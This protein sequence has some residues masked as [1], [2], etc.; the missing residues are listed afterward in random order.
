MGR[1][2][3]AQLVIFSGLKI[4][5]L[6]DLS[7]MID[8]GTIRWVFV[9]GSLAMA[10]RKAA[11][12]LEGRSFSLGKAENPTHA[13]EPWYIP[14]ERIEQAKAHDRR[15]KQEGNSIRTA[16]RFYPARW[17]ASETIGPDDQQFDIG[18][19][20]SELFER[21]IGEFLE[22][23][24]SSLNHQSRQWPSTTAYSACSKI[25]ASKRERGVSSRS[26]SG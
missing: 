24:R 12:E 25:H 9:A 26:S 20:T 6:D 5:K 23:V 8:R 18:P 1:C 3:D 14:A 19:K 2:L 15:R 21:K 10:L 7:A 17:T 22:S 4:D 11:A 13:K 16:G